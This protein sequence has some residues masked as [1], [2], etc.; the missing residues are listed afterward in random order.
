MVVWD[1]VGVD[2]R[3]PWRRCAPE[4]R[5][6]WSHLTAIR[7]HVICPQAAV[8]GACVLRSSLPHP[9][10]HLGLDEPVGHGCRCFRS[11]ELVNA[12]HG[13]ATIPRG[14]KWDLPVSCWTDSTSFFVAS[15]PLRTCA[16]CFPARLCSLEWGTSPA[17]HLRV[18]KLDH[19]LCSCP[20]PCL[21]LGL[22]VRPR[23]AEAEVDE[24]EGR[25][26]QWDGRHLGPPGAGWLLRCPPIAI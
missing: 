2:F 13:L 4:F 21:G 15:L 20:H 9:R 26:C 1:G 14:A 23:G 12:L 6:P 11:T 8:P 22:S 24:A 18:G 25:P 7:P 3:P 17:V 10:I 19:L 16:C 5:L